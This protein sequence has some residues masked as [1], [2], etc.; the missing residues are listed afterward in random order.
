MANNVIFANTAQLDKISELLKGYPT[1]AVKVLNRV[2]Y[3]A[4]DTVR[5]ETARLVPTVY[6]TTQKEVRGAL[7]KRK[8]KVIAGK[9]GTGSVSVEVIG[10][11]L[12]AVRFK[13]SPTSPPQ[14]GGKRQRYRAS[15]QIFRDKGKL[16]L[17][18]QRGA[19]GKPKSVF[20]APTGSE[21]GVPYIFF[22][23]TGAPGEKDREG[24]KAIRTLA[25]PQMVTNPKVS[26]PLV[27]KVNATIEKRLI[28][29]LDRE[30]GNLG[31]N[32]KGG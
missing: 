17:K 14:T 30:F 9:A 15:V 1:T 18:P 26:D 25:I 4:V 28:H 2:L 5:V 24:V 32:L 31:S 19:D 29:E 6:A 8:V 16:L 27:E 11:P 21:T 12:T 10:R 22:R 20:I 23:R 3:R 13:H 7:G